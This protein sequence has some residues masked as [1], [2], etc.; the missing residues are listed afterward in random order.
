M[1]I[2]RLTGGLGNQMF[3]YAAGL[4]LAERRRTV[5]KLDVGWFRE[6]NEWASHGRYSLDG[7]LLPAHFGTREEMERAT[8]VDLTRSER[9][10]LALARLLHF[11]QY[12]NR[13]RTAARVYRPVSFRYSADFTSLPDGT[14]L[15][16]LFQSELY[17]RPSQAE[18]RRH[19][20]FRFPLSPAATSALAAIRAAPSA[21]LHVRRGDYVSDLRFSR[22]L[23]V[24]DAAYYR[25]AVARLLSLQPA[26]RLHVFSDDPAAAAAMLRDVADFTFVDPGRQMS[27][28]EA[29]QLMASCDHGIVANSSFSWW[30]AWLLGNPQKTV[31]APTPWYA[32]GSHDTS[33]VIPP[34]W[35]RQ[36]AGFA[37]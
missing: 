16:G 7:F 5:L 28:H 12:E 30:A 8:G 19:F 9:A 24:L 32:G 21:F 35:I 6:T 34:E 11:R 36:A 15:D 23:G 13:L 26:V 27:V 10:S 3:Q 1:I 20:S 4:A 37:R 17:F 33:D 25:A 2:T 22:D 18:V 31:I 14:Y 29:L